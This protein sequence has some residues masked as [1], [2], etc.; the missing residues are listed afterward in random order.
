MAQT[1][2]VRQAPGSL[3]LIGHLQGEAEAVKMYACL[4]A[5][6][7]IG[8]AVAGASGTPLQCTGLGHSQVVNITV[9]GSRCPALRCNRSFRTTN[10][11]SAHLSPFKVCPALRC[12]LQHK[13]GATPQGVQRRLDI[14]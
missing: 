5:L 10:G 2:A 7:V 11:A 9:S 6:R 8:A 14:P 4:A 12:D 13:L 1:A 3:H